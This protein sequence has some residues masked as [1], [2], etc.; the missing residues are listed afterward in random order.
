ME[1]VVTA[2][3]PAHVLRLVRKE[4]A[5]IPVLTPALTQ[6]LSLALTLTLT[7]ALILALTVALTPALTL[8][9]TLV[10]TPA[11]T[12]ALLA[13]HCSSF[14]FVREPCLPL[15]QPLLLLCTGSCAA[16]VLPPLPS[17]PTSL[18]LAESP[19]SPPPH[20]PHP[21][22]TQPSPH[23]HTPP[24]HPGGHLAAPLRGVKWG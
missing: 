5:P 24:P 22:P 18:P 2:C 12:L 1:Q 15:P 6:A 19:P 14:L 7:P 13:L 10:L 23:P 11:L 4:S 8:T 17:L 20:T 16:I 9:L 3:L 21:T